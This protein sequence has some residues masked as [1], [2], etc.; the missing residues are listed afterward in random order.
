MTVPKSALKKH[1]GN[2]ETL[3]AFLSSSRT[4]G[5]VVAAL[6]YAEQLAAI[7]RDDRSLAALIQELWN[8]TTKPAVQ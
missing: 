5:D 4:A 7:A 1:P 2:R 6:A 8:Q 3:L